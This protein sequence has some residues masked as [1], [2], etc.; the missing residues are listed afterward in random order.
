MSLPPAEECNSA[1]SWW[2]TERRSESQVPEISPLH[3][4]APVRCMPAKLLRGRANMRRL[5]PQSFTYPSWIAV[6]S[7]SPYGIA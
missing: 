2:L 4:D 7:S 5:S 1:V 6:V 3:I